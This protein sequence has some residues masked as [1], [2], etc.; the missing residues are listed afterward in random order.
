MAVSEYSPGLPRPTGGDGVQ[1]SLLL[2]P[3]NQIV[4]LRRLTGE[5]SYADQFVT[6]CRCFDV[7]SPVSGLTG[8]AIQS[9]PYC[10]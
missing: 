10:R 3:S 2:A 5:R 7:A 4:S 1:L 8:A 9:L 6:R